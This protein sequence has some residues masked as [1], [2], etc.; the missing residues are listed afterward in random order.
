MEIADSALVT[1]R[2][3]IVPDQF[4]KS[5]AKVLKEG[6]AGTPMLSTNYSVPRQPRLC[7]SPSRRQGADVV[8]TIRVV[9]TRDR[10]SSR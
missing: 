4:E 9:E 10:S 1:V 8:P 5:V 6:D 2:Q 7:Q 3:V